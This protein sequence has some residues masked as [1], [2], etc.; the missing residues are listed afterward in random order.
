[1]VSNLESDENSDVES[2]STN[3]VSSDHEDAFD[4][5]NEEFVVVPDDSNEGSEVCRS[6]THGKQAIPLAE[7]LELGKLCIE[8][9]KRF[10]AAVELEKKKVN[11]CDKKKKCVNKTSNIGYL[12]TAVREF[13]SDL[14]GAKH[15][16]QRLKNALDMAWRAYKLALEHSSVDPPPLKKQRR[17][18]G[19][20]QKSTAPDVRVAL[21]DW[22]IDIR[23]ALKGRL[24]KKM[25]LAQCRNFYNS[26]LEQQNPSIP[27]EKQVKFSNNWITGWM[28]EY[29]VSLKAAN[30]RFKI[31]QE[32]RVERIKEYIMNIWRVQKFFLD[33]Y[34]VDPP[35]IN[36]DQM[37]L[38]RNESA[39]QKT[40]AFTGQD[41]FVKENYMFSR[42]RIT[43]YTQIS[44]DNQQF[45]PEFVFKGKGTRTRL[46]PP[47]GIKFQ[48]AVKGSYRL[49]HMLKTISNLR[50]RH[51]IFTAKNYTIY[52]LDDYSVHLMPDI[53]DALM[54]RGNILMGIGGG[55][56]GDIQINDWK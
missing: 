24:P 10:D 52:V 28:K 38:H 54:K 20:G 34:G 53:K 45:K 13:Y 49:E 18:F 47:E 9:K 44:S 48:W 23:G 16:D 17:A 26:W 27:E 5:G 6:Y 12:A 11:Y 55:I 3:M 43:A 31:K 35:V 40:L 8:H 21:Y 2:D 39:S 42:E 25:F 50:N 41:T 51:N 15:N 33:T 1:M 56:T 7:R 14:R 46:N 32:D 30:K 37:P 36:G 19:G 22:F 4:S 29:G